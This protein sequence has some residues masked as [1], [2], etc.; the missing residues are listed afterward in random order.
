M[1]LVDEN[2]DAMTEVVNIGVGR[3]AASLSELVGDR[4]E[5]HVPELRMVTLAEADEINQGRIS[6]LQAFA[7]EI[8]GKALLSFPDS[9]GRNLAALLAGHTSADDIQSCE[10][11][12]IL[13]EVGNIVLNGVLGSIANVLSGNLEYDVPTFFVDRKLSELIGD[14]CDRPSQHVLV[15]DAAM[16]VHS[17]KIEGRVLIAFGL[18]S[19]ETVLASLHLA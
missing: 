16:S 6:V 4:I 12:G 5:L 13:S 9:S 15:A 17:R 1:Q 11:S 2:L 14:M 3:A 18:G 10:V 19:I 7:G 8:S